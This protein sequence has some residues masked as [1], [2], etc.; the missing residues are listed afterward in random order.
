MLKTYMYILHKYYSTKLNQGTQWTWK[1]KI[2]HARLTHLYDVCHRLWVQTHCAF[3]QAALFVDKPI[4]D[5]V[6]TG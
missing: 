1:R 6:Q 3:Y 4:N 2:V 5:L